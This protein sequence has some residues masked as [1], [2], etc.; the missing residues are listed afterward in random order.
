MKETS[1]L[2]RQTSIHDPMGFNSTEKC[3]LQQTIIARSINNSRL[4]HYR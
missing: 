2:S 4:L 1:K 3:A